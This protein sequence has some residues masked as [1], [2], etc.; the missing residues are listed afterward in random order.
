MYKEQANKLLRLVI[1]PA[2]VEVMTFVVAGAS[3]NADQIAREGEELRVS[4]IQAL[5]MNL[6]TQVLQMWCDKLS[7]ALRSTGTTHPPATDLRDALYMVGNLNQSSKQLLGR[8]QQLQGIIDAIQEAKAA[9][10]N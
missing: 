9:Q 7:E 5:T 3:Q 6:P 8:V 1:I 2:H 10:L 4:L